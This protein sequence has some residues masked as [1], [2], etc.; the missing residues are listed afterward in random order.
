MTIVEAAHVIRDGVSAQEIAS[1]YGY[2]PNRSG[3]IPCPFHAEK[4]ASLKLHKSGWYCYGCGKGGSV[5]DFVMLHE[6]YNF[7]QAVKAIDGNL[8]LGLLEVK[9]VSLLADIKQSKMQA[10]FDK[11]KEQI[12]DAINDTIRLAS[13]LLCQHWIVYRDAWSTPAKERTG[14]QWDAMINEREWCMYYEDIIA[15]L[16]KQHEEVIAWR[17]T[18]QNPHSA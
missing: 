8:G 7:A 15:E 17:I 1:R 16:M 6:G 9:R 3:Y 5:I 10:N 4:T 14:A 18:P 13:G 11:V 2:T 12:K